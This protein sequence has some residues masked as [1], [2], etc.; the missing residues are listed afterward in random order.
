MLLPDFSTPLCH[1]QLLTEGEP[2]Q[3]GVGAVADPIHLHPKPMHAHIKQASWDAVKLLPNNMHIA[4]F[5]IPC[6]CCSTA[7][8]P[9][10]WPTA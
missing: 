5:R 3:H 2:K 10:P 9:A 1:F 6:C 8:T 7:P 4:V